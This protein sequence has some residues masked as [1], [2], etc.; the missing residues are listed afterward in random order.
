[1]SKTFLALD[2]NELFGE[3]DV[4]NDSAGIGR[5]ENWVCSNVLKYPKSEM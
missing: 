3:I 4:T 2:T 1:M 5:R